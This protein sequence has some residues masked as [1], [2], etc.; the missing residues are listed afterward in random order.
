MK[1][2]IDLSDQDIL[3]IKVLVG[4]EQGY[5]ELEARLGW[6]R[7]YARMKVVGLYAK[8][9]VDGVVGLAKFAVRNKIVK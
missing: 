1:V 6:G 8:I 7:T 4:E 2:E 5:K 9:G 3:M